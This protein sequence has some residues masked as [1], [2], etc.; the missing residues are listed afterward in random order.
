MEGDLKEME[1]DCSVVVSN[2]S[3]RPVPVFDLDGSFTQRKRTPHK[4]LKPPRAPTKASTPVSRVFR[5]P[6]WASSAGPK[7]V[8]FKSNNETECCKFLPSLH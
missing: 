5:T 8:S 3:P 7:Q 4:E 2:V 6:K 1:G